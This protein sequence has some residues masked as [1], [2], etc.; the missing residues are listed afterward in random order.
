M[1]FCFW[2]E[3]ANALKGCC[4]KECSLHPGEL[5]SIAKWESW[6]LKWLITCF[7]KH[8]SVTTDEMIL[9]LTS[10]DPDF[11]TKSSM[12]QCQVVNS[13]LYCHGLS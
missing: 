2:L 4:N 1:P 7:A 8:E 6:L 10:L 9:L 3:E 5:C 13:F 11:A 12:A